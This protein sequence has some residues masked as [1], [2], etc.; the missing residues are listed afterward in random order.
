MTVDDSIGTCWEGKTYRKH[1]GC[2]NIYVIIDYYKDP[3]K[4]GKIE[5][6]LINGDKENRCGNS[7]IACWN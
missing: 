3:E 6:I 5:L 2:G 4:K 1:T 7:W